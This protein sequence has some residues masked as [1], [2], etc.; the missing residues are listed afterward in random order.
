[1]IARIFSKIKGWLAIAGAVLSAIGIA[2][3]RGRHSG[4]QEA[5]TDSLKRDVAARDQQLEMNRE[6]TKFE[7]DAAAMTDEQAKAEAKAWARR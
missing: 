2:Y 3:L 4:K 5:N 7:R 1:M 6:A